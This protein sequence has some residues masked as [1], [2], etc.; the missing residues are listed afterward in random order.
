MDQ[1][2][3]YFVGFKGANGALRYS[4]VVLWIVTGLVTLAAP[5]AAQ[6]T[7]PRDAK[8]DVCKVELRHDTMNVR[9]RA[10][11][12]WLDLTTLNREIVTFYIGALN[13]NGELWPQ[14]T[15]GR[16]ARRQGRV[17]RESPIQNA[18]VE[19]SVS[20]Q[21]TF[22]TGFAVFGLNQSAENIRANACSSG[23][24]Y[25]QTPQEGVFQLSDEVPVE[26]FDDSDV[27]PCPSR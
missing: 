20:R 5:A 26:S 12:Q 25:L 8:L 27:S 22:P 11:V 4:F 15:S 24:C 3:S 23:S 13:P 17:Q 9:L 21:S 14:V 2:S 18:E 7:E 10:T 6:D 19:F 16:I 1:I